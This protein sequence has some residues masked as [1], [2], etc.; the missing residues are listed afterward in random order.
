MSFFINSPPVVDFAALVNSKGRPATIL[1]I[2]PTLHT[3][4]AERSC[5]DVAEA[6]SKAGGRAIVVS[7]GGRWVGELARFNATHITLNVKSKNPWRI[8]RNSKILADLIRQN[9]VDIIHARSRAPAWSAYL[10][11]KATNIPFMTTFH[12]AYKFNGRLKKRYNSVMAKGKRVIAVSHYIAQHIWDNYGVETNLIR[13]I[14]RGTAFDRF[15]PEMIHPE[16]MIKLT[17]DWSIPEDKSLILMPNRLSRIK[18]HHVLI[19]ALSKLERR[20]WFCVICGAEPGNIAYQNELMDLIRQHKLEESI[21]LVGHLD[22]VPAGM[23]LAQMTVVPSIVPESFGRMSVEAQAVGCP[24]I[25]SRIGGTPE[26]VIDGETG[27]LVNPDDAVDLAQAIGQALSLTLQQRQ[28]M[29]AKAMA[30][31][32]ANFSKTDMQIKTLDVYREIL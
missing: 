22:D 15:N 6:I 19:E 28:I 8:W 24:I 10:A 30:F 31:V 5:I 32:H 16:R 17:R 12:A 13:I 1:Q 4:G 11:S 14:H 20:D 3:G 21:R 9:D 18:G 25:V 26:T 7:A 2:I 27:Y 29:A 23:R